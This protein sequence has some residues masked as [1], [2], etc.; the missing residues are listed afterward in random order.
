MG[1]VA[2]SKTTRG[3]G[4]VPRS[5]QTGNQ[6]RSRSTVEQ[7][8]QPMHPFSSPHLALARPSAILAIDQHE[9]GEVSWQT[10]FVSI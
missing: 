4:L 5:L 2:R 9:I 6:P 1:N 8:R 10:I 7:A 3:E